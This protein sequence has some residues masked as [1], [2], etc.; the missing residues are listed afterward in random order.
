MIVTD[1]DNLNKDKPSK[2]RVLLDPTK[3]KYGSNGAQIFQKTTSED[4][5]LAKVE[6]TKRKS[7]ESDKENINLEIINESMP[8]TTRSPVNQKC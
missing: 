2:K 1:R 3:I 6:R 8:S 4:K 7:Q 5:K